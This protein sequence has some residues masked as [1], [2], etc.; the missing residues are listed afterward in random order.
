MPG[1][2]AV[3]G[4]AGGALLSAYTTG[5]SFEAAGYGYGPGIGPGYDKLVLIVS[6]ASGPRWGPSRR[7]PWR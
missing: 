1:M 4:S 5:G 7:R 2:L 3:Q 6:R